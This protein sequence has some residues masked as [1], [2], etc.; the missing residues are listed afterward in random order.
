MQVHEELERLFRDVFGN[1]DIV[2]T[3]D[4]T[5]DNIAEWDSLGH[6]NL[7]FSIEERFGVHFAG[8]ELA[9]FK[10]VGELRRFLET[11]GHGPANG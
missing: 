3:D 10:N 8:N 4:T 11:N 7:M 6:V 9:E 1:E 2:L 5:A